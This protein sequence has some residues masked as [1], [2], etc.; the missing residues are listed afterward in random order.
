ME[1]IM[2]QNNR[3]RDYLELVLMADEQ[4]S[5]AE[6]YLDKGEMFLLREGA[7]DI[8]ECIVVRLD[9]GI[10]ELKNLAV[11][12]SFRRMGYGKKLIS[13]LFSHYTDC[14][15][16]YVGTGES[17]VTLGF[18]RSCGF[19]FSHRVKNFFLENYDHPIFEGGIQLCDMIY[20]RRED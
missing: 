3:K 16:M 2:V 11:A 5:M 7:E 20:L 14:K 9:K 18:Y 10:Y 13:F 6:R 15:T 19:S 17:D 12:P 1:I 8:A 4:L